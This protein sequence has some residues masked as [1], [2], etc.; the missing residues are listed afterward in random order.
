MIFREIVPPRIL[1]PD[2]KVINIMEKSR[3]VQLNDEDLDPEIMVHKSRAEFCVTI[4]EYVRRTPFKKCV[5]HQISKMRI[6]S[7]CK[8]ETLQVQQHEGLLTKQSLVNDE[9]IPLTIS[10]TNAGS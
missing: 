9:R 10:N 8:M 7:T 4:G 6:P 5:S 2:E 3:S 1:P